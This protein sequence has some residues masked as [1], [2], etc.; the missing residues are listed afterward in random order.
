VGHDVSRLYIYINVCDRKNF[1]TNEP[2][3]IRNIFEENAHAAGGAGAF[4][5]DRVREID[6]VR[7]RSRRIRDAIHRKQT[8]AKTNSLERE[9]VGLLFREFLECFYNDEDA[10][11]KNF[12]SSKEGNVDRPQNSKIDASRARSDGSAHHAGCENPHHAGCENPVATSAARVAR[13]FRGRYE[14]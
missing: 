1:G 9:R 12:I 8:Q 2:R 14:H 7:L 5:R 3:R 13:R 4:E 6:R 11:C 10:H